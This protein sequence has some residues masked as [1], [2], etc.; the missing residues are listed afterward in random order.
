MAGF[1]EVRM[2]SAERCSSLPLDHYSG[3]QMSAYSFENKKPLLV[4]VLN[5]HFAYGKMKIA[6]SPKQ[7][8]GANI[9]CSS[10]LSNKLSH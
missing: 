6:I 5:F 4:R 9:V 10:F 7:K 8:R 2:G 1:F 3:F